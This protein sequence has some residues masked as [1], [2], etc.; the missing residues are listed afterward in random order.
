VAS[1]ESRSLLAT[2]RERAGG[3]C[4]YRHFPEGAAELSFQIDHIVA[5]KHRGEATQDNLASACFFCNSYK[6]AN[7]AGSIPPPGA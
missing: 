1:A 2:V 5:V 7:I 4:E 6:G 3:H